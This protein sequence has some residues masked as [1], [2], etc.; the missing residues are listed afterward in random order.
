MESPASNIDA[1]GAFRRAYPEFVYREY[2]WKCEENRLTLFFTYEFEPGDSITTSLCLHLP[3]MVSEETVRAHEGY[4]Y[5]IG[6][7]EA[8]SYWKAHCS[9][10]VRIACGALADGERAWWSNL[11]YEGLGEFRYRNGLLSVPEDDWVQFV[12]EGAMKTGPS[13]ITPELSGNLIAFTGG[14]DSTLALGLMRDSGLGVNELFFIENGVA[15]QRTEIKHALGVETYSE[16]I[17]ERAMNPRLLALNAEGALNGHTPFSAVAAFAGIFVAALR[18]LRYVIVANESSANQPTVPG[19]DINHQY[20]KSSTFEKKFQEYCASVW[21]TGPRY[22]SLLRPLSE[23]G[24]ATMLKK[25]E[26]ALPYV[27]SCNTKVK[28]NLWC[29]RCPKCLFAYL[30]FAA[31]KDSSFAER[32][33]GADMFADTTMSTIMHELAG[34]APTRPFECVGTTQESL[35]ALSVIFARFPETRHAPLLK[36]FWDSHQ[37]ML[38]S[39][40]LFGH[41][42]CEFHEHLIPDVA[43]VEMLKQAQDEICYG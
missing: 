3:E 26:T 37:D 15:E 1:F 20:S 35:A 5:R 4:I 34:L 27:S 28:N 25:Y 7:V 22:F 18:G 16:T 23:V 43:Y 12:C 21:P 17:I 29:G 33:I 36:E 9:S 40:D 32:M 2:S 11:W 31:V 38:L 41:L 8:L 14:K 39:P 24:I 19:T 10:R 30:L 13:E 42:A 6:L